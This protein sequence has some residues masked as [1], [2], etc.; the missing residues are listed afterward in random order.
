MVIWCFT[1]D[2]TLKEEARK[3]IVDKENEIFASAANAW[4][5]SIKKALGKL[6][7]PNNFTE[8]LS[9][10]QFTPLDI[11]V[12]HALKV[13]ELPIQPN[14]KDPFDRLLVAQ[15]LVEGL[16]LITRDTH[17]TAYGVPIIEA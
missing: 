7:A 12:A 14:H 4:E 17:L 5:I 15:A 16:T 3:I 8:L 1:N 2:P 6:K 9:Q 10:R 13:G 11:T